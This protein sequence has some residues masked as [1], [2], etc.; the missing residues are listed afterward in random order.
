M[1]LDWINTEYNDST[2]TARLTGFEI[3]VT[4]LGTPAPRV[5]V[6]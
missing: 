1:T 2:A 4:S 5:A 6:R 3:R